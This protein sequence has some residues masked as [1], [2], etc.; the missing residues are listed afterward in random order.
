MGS[1]LMADYLQA[2]REHGRGAYD[3]LV[4]AGHAPGVVVEKARRAFFLGY[5]SKGER[6]PRDALITDLGLRFLVVAADG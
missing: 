5:V 3:V 1:L 2:V 6:W 4:G